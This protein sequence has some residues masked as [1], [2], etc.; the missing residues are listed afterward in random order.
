MG[1]C[2]HAG[3]RT[4]TVFFLRVTRSTVSV[5][6]PITPQTLNV[7]T[8]EDA[9]DLATT[10]NCSGGGVFEVLWQ[11]AVIVESTIALTDDCNV[12]IIGVGLDAVVDGGGTTQLFTVR[13]SSLYITNLELENGYGYSGG[14]VAAIGVYSIVS[15]S[16]NTT[17]NY[18]VA[19]SG[20]AVSVADG[21]RGFWTGDSSFKGNNA[22]G[23]Y[24]GAGE[25]T[26][27][28]GSGG[29]GGALHAAGSDVTWGGETNFFDNVA[30]LSGG[31][32][33][34]AASSSVSWTGQTQ[35]FNNKVH[36]EG[37]IGQD[38]GAIFV[39]D[40]DISWNGTTT[41]SNNSA[42]SDGGAICAEGSTNTAWSGPTTFSNNTANANGGTL[43]LLGVLSVDIPPMGNILLLSGNVATI[44]GGAVYQESMNTGLSWAGASFVSN[45]ALNGGAVYSVGSAAAIGS[46]PN[47]YDNC[48]FDDNSASASGG[49]IESTAGRDYFVDTTF[50]GNTAWNIGGGLRLAG[51]A[52][53]SRCI[54]VGNGAEG[55]GPAVSNVGTLFIVDTTF[56]KNAL[57]C[58]PDTFLNFTV[59]GNVT[60]D[61]QAYYYSVCERCDLWSGDCPVEGNGTQQCIAALAN[62]KSTGIDV[63]GVSITLETLNISSGYW[64]A[65]A[66]TATIRPCWNDD[67]CRGGMTG[68]AAYCAD[69]YRGPY[70]AICT[71]D[72]AWTSA[73]SCSKCSSGEGI[74]V[75][76]AALL[77][78]L[79]V[80]AAVIFYLASNT[81]DTNKTRFGDLL[82]TLPLQGL[83]PLVVAWQILTQTDFHDR[84]FFVTLGSL[85]ALDLMGVSF[86]VA[87][88][89][90][91]GSQDE[92]QAARRKHFSM[93][94]LMTFLI[95]SSV[96]S[97]VFRVFDCET[98]EDGKEYLR[99]DYGIECTTAKHKNLEVGPLKQ[100]LRGAVVFIYPNTAA[101]VAVTVVLAFVFVMVSESLAPYASGKGAWM[102][103]VAHIVV[104]L[105]M[106]QSLV[107]KADVSNESSDSQEVFGGV[108]LAANACMVAA[109]ITEAVMVICSLLWGN[110]TD[111]EETVTPGDRI[112]ASTRNVVE[113]WD[114]IKREEPLTTLN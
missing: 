106:F 30:D 2:S 58:A 102:S 93:V 112:T 78:A 36:F 32:I 107:L 54:F 53:F 45:S 69:G 6:C 68:N 35:F 109:V 15:Y 79:V 80:F 33:H 70:C 25:T 27:N 11:G 64:R 110:G 55:P 22:T 41:F 97:T 13:N 85:I 23:V 51:T 17:F 63:D 87:A 28:G 40:S 19:S 52:T 34:T 113:G 88:R 39:V 96:S 21:A 50:K 31:A 73:Y 18:N 61:S 71:D 105:S 59:R 82:Q 108:L 46:S 91:R 90:S 9:R 3:W 94:L 114:M 103:R 86:H 7:T 81:S 43:A 67:A 95:F 37:N 16:E 60:R 29:T 4:F 65:T 76:V 74:A 99:A 98:L 44:V 47:S 38:G 20:G 100:Y 89:R 48:R 12:S 8:A 66:S 101:Q 83:K 57:L 62:T 92:L 24:G 72:Y 56:T 26:F 10:V 1:R 49:A 84:L 42:D 75:T 5:P 104:F 111:L 14:A 77:V